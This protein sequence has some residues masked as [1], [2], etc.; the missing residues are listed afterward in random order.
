MQLIITMTSWFLMAGLFYIIFYLVEHEC[1]WIFIGN[2]FL[3][4]LRIYFKPL[5]IF[6]I[7]IINILINF[8]SAFNMLLLMQL[9]LIF[10]L[11]YEWL[12]EHFESSSDFI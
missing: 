8:A 7:I 1:F 2:F 11:S 5:N 6:I 9:I 12:Q 10:D 4:D 3:R